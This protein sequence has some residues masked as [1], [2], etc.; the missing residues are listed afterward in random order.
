MFI[1]FDMVN[2]LVDYKYDDFHQYLIDNKVFKTVEDCTVYIEYILGMADI[3]LFTIK[4]AFD[5][6]LVFKDK[7]PELLE[8]MLKLWDEVIIEVPEM[9]DLIKRLK[10]KHKIRI[11][12]LSNIS[13][14]HSLIFRNKFDP[15]FNSCITHFSCSVGAKK[16][17]KI[18]FQS[19]L[20]DNSGFKG[21]LFFDDVESNVIE[22]QNQGF[23]AIQFR[24][25]EFTSFENAANSLESKI[26]HYKK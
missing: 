4:Q 1:A 22:A 11:A 19:F 20:Y 10:D 12:L 15:I 16:P 9:T 8:N 23:K 2:V 6:L 13:Y 26:L 14:E 18:Y 3:G 5:N 24:L 7:K 17:S 25:D 21:S